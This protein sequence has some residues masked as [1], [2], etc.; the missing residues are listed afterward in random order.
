[1]GFKQWRRK[2]RVNSSSV[3]E[4]Q[5]EAVVSVLSHIYRIITIEMIRDI[6]YRPYNRLPLLSLGILLERSS[7]EIRTQMIHAAQP[8]H[9]L[10]STIMGVPAPVGMDKQHSLGRSAS[11]DRASSQIRDTS[12]SS[13]LFP[14][15][16]VKNQ[17][18]SDARDSHRDT[19]Q[20]LM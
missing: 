9:A 10:P 19:K 17:S 14:V 15:E 2:C 13:S 20:A 18:S 12:T 6:V 8:D 5:S 4:E 16:D 11:H 1:M 3:D 7:R